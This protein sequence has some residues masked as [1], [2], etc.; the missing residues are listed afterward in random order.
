[1]RIGINDHID[2][3]QR[4]TGAAGAADPVNAARAAGARA[5]AGADAQLERVRARLD[6]PRR[7]LVRDFIIFELKQLLDSFKGLII[8]QV[9]VV[10][11]II[12]LLRPGGR[13]YKAFY[14]VMDVGERVDHWLSLYGA[15]RHAAEDPEGLMGESREGS[16]TMLGQLEHIV[17][18]VVV[19]DHEVEGELYPRS[20]A[21]GAPDTSGQPPASGQP[22]T[23]PGTGTGRGTGTATASSASTRT[24]T[25]PAGTDPGARPA[26]SPPPPS[27]VPRS[28][29]FEAENYGRRGGG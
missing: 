2:G 3:T 29:S 12:D 11:F 6:H 28:S 27:S 18:R 9:A 13:D 15:S 21:T 8:S 14:K 24:S 19:G 25:S 1:M 4:T 26:A 22:F 16:P 7:V 10:G 5:W 17:H 23:D 20:R